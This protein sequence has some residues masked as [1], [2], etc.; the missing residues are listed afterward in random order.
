[1]NWNIENTILDRLD[2]AGRG[3]RDERV[4]DREIQ[5]LLGRRHVGSREFSEAVRRQEIARA[6]HRP[7]F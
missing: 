4:A 5:D 2:R 1:M 3:S 6:S 7:G